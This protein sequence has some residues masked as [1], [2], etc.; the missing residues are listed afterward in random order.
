MNRGSCLCG[1]VRFEAGSFGSMEHC[2]CSMCRRHHGAMFATF[3][4]A[5]RGKFRFLSGEDEIVTYR[6]SERGLRPFC[7][8]CGS[9]LP[10]VLPGWPDTVFV[11]AG[12]LEDDPGIRPEFHMFAA[13]SPEWFPITDRLPR[14][15]TFP[16]GLGDR[17]ESVENAAPAARDGIVQGHCLCGDVV[18]ELAGTPEFVQNCHCSRCRRARS[19]AHATNAFFRHEQ[20]TWVRGEK[21]VTNFL[22]PGA[23]RFGQS[24][25]RRCGSPVA[26]VVQSTGYV[27]VPCGSLDGAPGRP[28]RGHI[29]V[30]SKAPWYEI[31]DGLPQWEELPA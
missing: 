12:N 27:V 31:T 2:H 5:E 4:T 25:C 20:L 21:D 28:P 15:A 19:A 9:V 1:A 10:V 7:R 26:R 14:Y 30:G 13:S 18:F 6:S 16:P 3:L 23:K 17:V 22:L 8:R 11:P 29:F 24:F